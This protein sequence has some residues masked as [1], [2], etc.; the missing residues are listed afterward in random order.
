MELSIGNDWGFYVDVDLDNPVEK[1]NEVKKVVKKKIIQ[2]EDTFNDS[3]CKCVYQCYFI[4]V[5]CILCIYMV[6]M[7]SSI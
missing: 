6:F 7:Y 1:K 3:S 2:Y 5:L 4:I